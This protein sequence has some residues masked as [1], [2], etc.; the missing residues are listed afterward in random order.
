MTQKRLLALLAPT[1]AAL[2]ALPA[3]AQTQV[4]QKVPKAAL[5][6]TSLKPVTVEGL[7]FKANEQVRVSVATGDK[8]ESKVVVASDKGT[9]TARFS[10]SV[11]RCGRFTAHAWGSR[12][13]RARLFPRFS[14]DCVPDNGEALPAL[15]APIRPGRP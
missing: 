15:P 3:A 8:S 12:G 13:S 1:L 2:T 7:R 11:G 9:F 14:L 5:Q 4:L 6:A 10:V